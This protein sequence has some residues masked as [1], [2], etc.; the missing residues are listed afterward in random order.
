[1]SFKEFIRSVP[2]GTNP[3]GD[4]IQD[5]RSDHR[6]PEISTWPELEHYFVRRAAIAEAINAAENVWRAYEDSTH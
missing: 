4:F 1:V 3:E 5:A 2:A 6:L